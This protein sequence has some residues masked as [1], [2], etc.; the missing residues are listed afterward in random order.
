MNGGIPV[1]SLGVLE[2]R[3]LSVLLVS[4]VS[5]DFLEVLRGIIQVSHW[6]LE[7]PIC[8]LGCSGFFPNHA[9]SPHNVP[10]CHQSVFR[11]LRCLR[12]VLQCLQCSLLMSW[13]LSPPG[14][15]P[16][17]SPVTQGSPEM[18]QGDSSVQG[19]SKNPYPLTHT[20]RSCRVG[21]ASSLSMATTS[22]SVLQGYGRGRE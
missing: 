17:A 18:F 1:V 16:L 19:L 15:F 12:I 2:V 21:A 20:C 8:C 6:C 7:C 4:R 13:Y 22:R 14:V 10:V 9:W 11:G 5:Q 3:S